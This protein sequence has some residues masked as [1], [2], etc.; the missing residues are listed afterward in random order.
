VREF[1]VL[2]TATAAFFQVVTTPMG[3]VTALAFGLAFSLV[4]SLAFAFRVAR[5]TPTAGRFLHPVKLFKRHLLVL[6]LAFFCGLVTLSGVRSM[7][8]AIEEPANGF[9][10]SGIGFP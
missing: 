4:L 10:I 1:A 5:G 2:A 6:E 9:V 7:C 8:T 3:D